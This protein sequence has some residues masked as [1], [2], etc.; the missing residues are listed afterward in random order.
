MRNEPPIAVCAY[1]WGQEFRLYKQYL[2]VSGTKYSL[3]DLTHIR[4]IY[5][6][7]MGISSVRIELRFGKQNVT[8][9]GIAA[10]DEAQKAIKYLTSLY[11]GLEQPG[12]SQSNTGTT[13]IDTSKGWVR[14]RVSQVSQDHA[15]IELQEMPEPATQIT[16]SLS[17]E[18]HPP[19]PNTQALSLHALQ[20]FAKAP[21]AKI[22]ASNWQ[23]FRQEQRERRQRR[24]HVERSLREHGFDIAQ[25]EQRLNEEALPEVAVPLRLLADER[26]HYRT[27][28]TL[29]G[30]PVSGAIRYTYPAKEHGTLILTN[31]RLLYIGRK[32]Q[33]VLD[34][35]RLL[36]VS[37]LRGAIAFQAEHWYQ[38][39]IFEVPRSLECTMFLEHILMRFQREQQLQALSSHGRYVQFQQNREEA[40]V[41]VDIN[42]MP[43]SQRQWDMAEVIDSING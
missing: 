28:A 26:A 21:T 14:Q 31:K 7:L 10:V 37:R 18:E 15:E 34:Y 36:H 11:L 39:E 22:T 32:S 29:C 23:R 30:E 25:L 43:L 35:A 4:S 16:E 20:T 1:G 42:T 8:L 33:I 2:I 6:K 13:S 9:R 41:A 38:R 40:P 3:S 27:E 19:N 24:L 17:R 5:Q 12:L